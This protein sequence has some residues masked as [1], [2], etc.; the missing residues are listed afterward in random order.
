MAYEALNSSGTSVF[1]VTHN[2]RV[3]VTDGIDFSSYAHASGMSSELL[4]DYEE[5][6]WTPTLPNGGTMIQV[7][8]ARYTKV[9]RL[10][11]VYC[12]VNTGSIPSNGTEFRI[13]GLPFTCA[14]GNYYPSGSI[15][16]T[17]TFNFDPWRPLARTNDDFIYFHRCNGSQQVALNSNASGL[18]SILITL[19]YS[20]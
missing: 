15:G 2:G 19:T 9:G 10:V 12:Y 20:V 3:K 16:Y 14:N 8:N 11:N 1:S 17:A 6:T 13:G 4:N 5:G 18:A 7:Y